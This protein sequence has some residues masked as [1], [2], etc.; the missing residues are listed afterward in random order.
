[1]SG[2]AYFCLIVSKAFH[3][4]SNMMHVASEEFALSVTGL[5]NS[6]SEAGTRNRSDPRSASSCF[7]LNTSQQ[8][9]RAKAISFL[10]SQRTY[11]QTHI[12][13]HTHTPHYTT[14]THIRKPLFYRKNSLQTVSNILD[15]SQFICM[16]VTAYENRSEII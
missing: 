16:T 3:W 8:D 6:H 7:L 11:T 2:V 13:L 9:R 12:P 10:S 4:N 14:L 5:V 15:N 1:M